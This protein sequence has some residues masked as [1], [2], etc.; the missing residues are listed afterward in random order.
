LMTMF[1]SRTNLSAQ[2]VAEVR[3]HFAAQVFQTVIPRTVRLSEAPGF[4]KS[5]F[6]YAPNGSGARAYR[7]LAEEFL[8]R[9]TTPSPR[10]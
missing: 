1:D 9:Q 5:I 10:A 8:L 3:E 7:A 4:G 6:E 2:V